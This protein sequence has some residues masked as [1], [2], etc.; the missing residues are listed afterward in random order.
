GPWRVSCRRVSKITTED[1]NSDNSGCSN[2]IPH[3]CLTSMLAAFGANGQFTKAACGKRCY[4]ALLKA[5]RLE[6]VAPPPKKQ[7]SWHNDGP[8]ASVSSLSALIKWMTDGNSSHRYHGGDGQSGETKQALAGEVIAAIV[9]SGVRSAAA[10]F[11]AWS[12]FSI[13]RR[14]TIIDVRL[15]VASRRNS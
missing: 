1:S 11:L 13:F 5:L 12:T 9:A 4:N 10:S 14:A 15:N 6:P 2:S 8:D 7:I 3:A